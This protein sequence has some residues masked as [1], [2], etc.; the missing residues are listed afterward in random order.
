MS[1]TLKIPFS[2]KDKE[3][4]QVWK[5]AVQE[6]TSQK[7]SKSNL[8]RHTITIP[9][10]QASNEYAQ[11]VVEEALDSG[12]QLPKSRV[13]SLPQ[14]VIEGAKAAFIA[15]GGNISEVSSL[16]DL[17]PEAVIKLA[18]KENWPVYGGSTKAI[19]SKSKAQLTILRDKLWLRIETFLDSMEIEKKH[20]DDIVQHRTNSEYIEPLQS[21]S[22]A[23]KTLMDQYMRVSTL[24]EPEIFS[25]DPDGSNFHARNARGQSY[26]GGI[27]GVNREM[28]D[29]ISEIVVGIADKYRD[30]EL[31]GYGD[32]ID[33][34]GR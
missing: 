16:Y 21:R 33:M 11:K 6:V 31:Q 30:K 24:L 12:S 4:L 29:F 28:A 26:P 22:S 5:T 23:F 10:V 7:K 27:E 3:D 1:D 19:E 14:E 20:K 32:I 2:R 25:A 17:T 34:R 18:S 9:P 8:N 13:V 15:S